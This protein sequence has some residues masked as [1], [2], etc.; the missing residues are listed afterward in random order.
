MWLFYGTL[1]A[2]S[3][4]LYNLFAKL[5]AGKFSPTIALLIINGSSF[6]VAL[7]ATFILKTAGRPLTFT[8]QSLLLPILAGVAT[9]LAEICYYLMYTKHAELGIGT[10]YVTGGTVITAT[11]LGF[12]IL[13]EPIN[14]TKAV[15]LLFVLLGLFMIAK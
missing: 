15:G 13:R 4:G 5:A 14:T 11:I 8:A 3:F 2:L 9:G 12:I 6:I 7:V 1:A 10:T